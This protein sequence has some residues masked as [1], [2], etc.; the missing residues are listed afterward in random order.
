VNAITAWWQNLPSKIDPVI[1]ALG[2]VHIRWY[3]LMYLVVFACVYY[4]VKYRIRTE[5]FDYSDETISDLFFW[6]IVAVIVGGRLGYVLFYD[7]PFFLRN[8]LAIIS[9]FQMTS[10]GFVFTGIYG[11]SYHGGLFAVLMTFFLYTKKQGIDLWRFIDLFAPAVPLGYTFGR[12][13]NF[14]NGELYGRE[15]ARVWGMY[16]PLDE[17]GLL[18]HPSQLYE[19][20]FE[21]LFLFALLWILRKKKPFEGFLFALYLIG[22]GVVRF[23]IEFLREPDEHLGLVVGSFAMGQI[24]CLAMILSGMFILFIRQKKI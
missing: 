10:E 1:F 2:P 7:L 24:L 12:L 3:G 18:R 17:A 22:Y 8:P 13:G 9:P 23:F 21:G 5:D 15:T 11:M 19:A 20:F 14:L 16:F 4:L 6:L